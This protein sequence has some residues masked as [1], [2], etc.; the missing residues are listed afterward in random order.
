MIKVLEGA[1]KKLFL[2]L[3]LLSALVLWAGGS[4]AGGLEVRA[5]CPEIK[6]ELGLCE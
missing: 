3:M 1:M 4:W 5:A 2:G 6:A